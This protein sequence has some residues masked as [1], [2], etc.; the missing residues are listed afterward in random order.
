MKN[1][2][3]CFVIFDKKNF[4]RLSKFI[5]NIKSKIKSKI[6]IDFY[7][8]LSSDISTNE[9]KEFLQK[10]NID[11]FN[12]KKYQDDYFD[13]SA[14][15]DFCRKEQHES[16]AII[17]ANDTLLS[18]HY[19]KLLI[20]KFIEKIN[21]FLEKKEEYTL[22]IGPYCLS[23]F[24]FQNNNTDSFVPTYL[25]FINQSSINEFLFILEKMEQINNDLNKNLDHKILTPSF[26][27]FAKTHQSQISCRYKSKIRLLQKITTACTERMITAHFKQ[28]GIVW[29]FDYGIINQTII[30]F[31]KLKNKLLCLFR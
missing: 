14:Y 13:Y 11:N 15:R 22:L 18:K 21:L 9:L 10:K 4:E 12:V 17:F 2:S 20:N 1:L 29:Y 5:R 27:S 6:K 25:F 7:I 19:S 24:S 3:I 28:V 31:E 30:K 16:N 26:I 8:P 23:E